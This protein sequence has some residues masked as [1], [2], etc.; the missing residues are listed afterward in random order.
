MYNNNNN[1]YVLGKHEEEIGS[2]Q[3][4]TI[5]AFFSAFPF[6]KSITYKSL[7]NKNDFVIATDISNN[8]IPPPKGRDVAKNALLGIAY[9]RYGYGEYIVLLRFCDDSVPM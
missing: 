9:A 4:A 6:V 1:N 7:Y 3:H 8:E 2:A 5:I